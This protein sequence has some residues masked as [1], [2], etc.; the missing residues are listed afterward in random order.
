MPL[1]AALAQLGSK[2]PVASGLASLGWSTMPLALRERAFFTSRVEN[3]RTVA[4]AKNKIRDA[5]SLADEGRMN[6]ATFVA[7]MRQLLGAAPGTTADLADITSRKR[8]ELI[9]N[10]NI[11]QAREYARW[12][13]GQDQDLLDEWPAQELIRWEDRDEPRN[14]PTRWMQAGG[15]FYNGRMIALKNDPIWE[16]ISRFGTPW[17]PFDFNSGMGVENIS[18]DEA[19]ALG[20]LDPGQTIA[21]RLQDFNAKLEA[22]LPDNTDPALLDTLKQL[23]G[24]QIATGADNKVAWVP[25]LV[26]KLYDD[27]IAGKNLNTAINLGNA[28]PETVSVVQRD[29]GVDLTGWQMQIKGDEI[30]HALKGHGAPGVIPGSPGETQSGQLPLGRDDLRAVPLIWWMPDSATAGQSRPDISAQPP[31]GWPSS[32]RLQSDIAGQLWIADY[33]V[34]TAGKILGFITGWRK[35]P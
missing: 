4:E 34:N 14:W 31:A 35:K 11:E 15:D 17:P 5:L 2:S 19:V 21:P 10:H 18:R 8:L 28:T 25:D 16:R 26:G 13:A 6:R 9:Y 29:L 7:E 32:I 30:R 3:L 33:Y 1:D 20:L 24:D 12:T 23:F 22:S 27:A